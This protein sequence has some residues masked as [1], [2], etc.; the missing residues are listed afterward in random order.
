MNIDT[1]LNAIWSRVEETRKNAPVVHN[2]TNF[3]VMHTTANALLAFG[4]SPVMA[5]EETEVDSMV[6]IA[7]SL[8][9]NIGTLSIP[10]IKGMKRA[11]LKAV[12]LGKP[13]IIDPVGA[14]ATP[15]R[16]RTALELLGMCP[17]AL[18]RGNA[19]EIL[20][21]TGAE[22]PSRGV[23]S[24]AEADAKA[25]EA[26]KKLA[27][28]YGCAVCVSGPVDF[29]TDGAHTLHLSGGSAMMPRVTGMGCTAT[30]LCGAI[31]GG[32]PKAGRMDALLTGMAVM[33]AAGEKA[34]KLCKGPGS[35]LI[36]FLD[37]LYLLQ[38]DDLNTLRIGQN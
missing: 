29:I 21:L 1:I 5:H 37:A 15:L 2:I 33:S 9:L 8:V 16:T 35:F 13:I 20:A 17:R 3:V 31:A 34:A 36:E 7:S 4:A 19:S 10:W 18:L 25:E 6:S 30:S 14:G 24:A 38:R 32:C 11:A 12:E 26:A 28:D 27:K 23:D 22:G